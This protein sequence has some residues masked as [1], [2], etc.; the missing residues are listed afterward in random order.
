MTYSMRRQLILAL[1]L[2]SPALAQEPSGG[3][4]VDAIAT[5]VEKRL[6]RVEQN[7]GRIADF[8][9]RSEKQDGPVAKFL[10]RIGNG[11]FLICGTVALAFVCLAPFGA[12]MLIR[13]IRRKA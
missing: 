6:E 12:A 11:V 9:E 5:R 8:F 7:T 1:I 2:L 3:P 4:V 10:D 13:E